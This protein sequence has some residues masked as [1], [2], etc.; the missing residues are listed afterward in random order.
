[1]LMCTSMG[2]VETCLARIQGRV[3]KGGHSIPESDVR[4]RFAR[5]ARN[6]WWQY[7]NLVDGWHL[8]YNGGV[9]FHEVALGKGESMEVRDEDIFALFLRIT[10]EEVI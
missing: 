2:S 6:F 10:G 5:S 7:R 1:M 9:H 3:R 8:L 4:R